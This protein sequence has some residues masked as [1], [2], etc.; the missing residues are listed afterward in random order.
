[1]RRLAI[2]LIVG[3]L[4]GGATRVVKARMS[5]EPT[6]HYAIAMVLEEQ[7]VHAKAEESMCRALAEHLSFGQPFVA[8]FEGKQK[9]ATFL[10]CVLVRD[11]IITDYVRGKD[12][13]PRIQ[14]RQRQRSIDFA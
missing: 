12:D 5:A 10:Y 13:Q 6:I 1:M 4:C 14:T 8:D 11:G 7:V 9:P 3:L 2:F